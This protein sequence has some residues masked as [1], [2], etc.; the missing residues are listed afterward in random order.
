MA[1]LRETVAGRHTTKGMLGSNY[2]NGDTSLLFG[3]ENQALVSSRC[4]PETFCYSA[5]SNNITYKLYLTPHRGRE[6]RVKVLP[7]FRENSPSSK[8]LQE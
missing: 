3:V 4:S 5:S 1:A 8:L 6:Y 2:W 7:P